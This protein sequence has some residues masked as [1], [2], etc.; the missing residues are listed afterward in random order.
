M[1]RFCRYSVIPSLALHG[2]ELEGFTCLVFIYDL[3]CTPGILTQVLIP[4]QKSIN[5]LT[6]WK[7]DF[8]SMLILP[9]A[10]MVSCFRKFASG[11]VTTSSVLFV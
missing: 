2:Q 8:E 6:L 10:H 7:N 9:N 3:I 4:L 11:S 5:G 1:A